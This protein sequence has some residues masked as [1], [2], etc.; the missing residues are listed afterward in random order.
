[1]LVVNSY[2]PAPSFTPSPAPIGGLHTI[3]SDIRIQIYYLQPL[4]FDAANLR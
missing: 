1:M 3:N 2:A 4:I